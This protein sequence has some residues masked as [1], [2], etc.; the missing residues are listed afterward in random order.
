M[1]TISYKHLLVS[2]F[3]SFYFIYASNIVIWSVA[4]FRFRGS[5]DYYEIMA[6]VSLA[7]NNYIT[8]GVG[9]VVSDYVRTYIRYVRTYI[10]YIRTYIHKIRTYIHTY[11]RYVH[12]LLMR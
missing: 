11:I 5:S 12:M 9:F 7:G 3:L 8:L 1:I 4:Q 6:P 2:E 10:R